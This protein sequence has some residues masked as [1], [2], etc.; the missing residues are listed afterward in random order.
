MLLVAADATR[1][2]HPTT[3]RRSPS[4]R[5]P[6]RRRGSCSRGA[7]GCGGPRRRPQRHD[8]VLRRSA[9]VALSVGDQRRS[10]AEW[11][12]AMLSPAATCSP[13]SGGQAD[14]D[15]RLI[16]TGGCDPAD[17]SD[18]VAGHIA[19]IE[20]GRAFAATRSRTRRTRAIGLISLYPHWEAGQ[21]RRPTLLDPMAYHPGHRG[22]QRAHDSSPRRGSQ[23]R[24]GPSFV[25]RDDVAADE[26][27]HPGPRPGQTQ[28]VVSSASARRP[29]R[30]SHDGPGVSD[31]PV[32]VATLAVASSPAIAIRSAAWG[33]AARG[34]GEPRLSGLCRRPGLGGPGR[35]RAMCLNLDMDASPNAARFVYDDAGAPPGSDEPTQRLLDALAAVGKPGLITDLG[36]ASDHANF[37]PPGSR[38][39]A[40][41]P[42]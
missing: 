31:A 36:G 9:P 35:D 20:S 38:R 8:D 34:A 40:S 14:A 37:E 30:G 6:G 29:R 13:G 24:V 26:R 42:A 1:R 18:F 28:D 33:L 32:S 27:Q 5:H 19:L 16:G 17:W 21:T 2:G 23:R 25:G 3:R 10:G 4:R 7:A 15:G 39:P 11:L 22:R 41:S 12:H